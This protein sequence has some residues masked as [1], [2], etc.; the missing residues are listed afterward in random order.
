MIPPMSVA[1]RDQAMVIVI[2]IQDRLATVMQRREEVV[3]SSGLVMRAAGIVGVPIVVTR[4]YPQGLGDLVV[5]IDG[6]QKEIESAGASVTRVDKMSF[7][8][9]AEPHFAEAVGGAGRR[10]LVLVGME[11]HICVTQT[12]LSGIREGYDV[13]VVADAC[14]SRDLYAHAT[15]ME[16][17]GRAGAVITLAE[18]LGYELVGVAGTPEFKSLLSAVKAADASR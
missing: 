12:A 17:L 2:D 9:F 8:C 3:A 6:V 5:E 11:S 10:Q 16:R 14:C 13:H 1:D 7:D 15:S 4:Q 18:S